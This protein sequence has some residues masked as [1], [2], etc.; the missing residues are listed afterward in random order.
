M[1][2]VRWVSSIMIVAGIFGGVYYE[3]KKEDNWIH[4]A[5][6]DRGLSINDE[7]V[8]FSASNFDK[9]FERMEPYKETLENAYFD[10]L[11]KAVEESLA[12]D[13]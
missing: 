4:K 5:A 13:K 6:S 8:G 1:L 3:E 10:S 7:D 12:K 9:Y 11:T 2:N